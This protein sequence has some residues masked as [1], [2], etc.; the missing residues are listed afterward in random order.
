M[1]EAEVGASDRLH[2]TFTD[3]CRRDEGWCDQLVTGEFKTPPE[4][5][6][7]SQLQQWHLTDYHGSPAL[8]RNNGRGMEEKSTNVSLVRAEMS[9]I[10]RLVVATV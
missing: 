4:S 2:R 8:V 6:S 3:T 7:I 1:R 10:A 5:L 9:E